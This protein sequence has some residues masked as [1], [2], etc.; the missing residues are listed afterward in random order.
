MRVSARPMAIGAKPW[1]ARVGGAEDDVEEDRGEQ[2]LGDEDRGEAVAARGVLAVS[3]RGHVAGRPRTRAP[4]AIPTEPRPARSPPTT[5]TPTYAGNVL[6][7]EALRDRD[8]DGDRRVE[9]G[10]RDVLTA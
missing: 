6:P 7:L 5:W 3:V 8:A 1:G 2:H 9:V 10:A 4:R